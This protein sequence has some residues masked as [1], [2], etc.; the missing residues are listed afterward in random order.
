MYKPYNCAPYSAGVHVA[1]DS[2]AVTM[3][4]QETKSLL[5]ELEGDNIRQV[6]IRHGGRISN[7][8][9]LSTSPGTLAKPSYVLRRAKVIAA[10][11]GEHSIR[12]GCHHPGAEP[13]SSKEF[14]FNPVPCSQE[15]RP[16]INLKKLN[17]G[18]EPQH[19]KMEGMGTLKEL[20]KVNN[21]MVKVDLK[22]AYFTIPIH[23][24]HQPFLR[25]RVKQQHYQFTCLPFGL[26]C[27]P[28][29]FTKVMK[30]LAILLW[31][32]GVHMIVYID[33]MLLMAESINQVEAHLEALI[34]LLTGLG[35]VINIPK[36]ITIPTQQIEFLWVCRWTPP[37]S[38]CAYQERNS[39]TSEWRSIRT[40]RGP[41]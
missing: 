5:H 6:G 19:F 13:S 10:E 26:S 12:E 17:E 14:L 18:V 36:S 21:W 15:R 24:D 8:L 31:S 22:D 3:C 1:T 28:W 16:V 33:G 41:R 7:P 4:G 29:V 23:A 27:A 40:Y 34:Y 2:T 11:R 32:M 38:N 30:P 25:F 37:P 39:T 20:L 35:F 9:H